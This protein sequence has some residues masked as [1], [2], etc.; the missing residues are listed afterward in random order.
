[1]K[2]HTTRDEFIKNERLPLMLHKHLQ[3]MNAY[4]IL[5]ALEV[6]TH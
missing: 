1:M 5:K 6:L 4:F 3:H 2:T